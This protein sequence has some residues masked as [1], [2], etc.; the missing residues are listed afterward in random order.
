MD[1]RDLNNI[2]IPLTQD[3]YG[4]TAL[5]IFLGVKKNTN[6]LGHDNEKFWHD[7]ALAIQ[8]TEITE[9]YMSLFL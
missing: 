9:H 2:E 6:R 4:D 7:R 1:P 3:I 5:D 8:E